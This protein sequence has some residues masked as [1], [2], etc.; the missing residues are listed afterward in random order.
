MEG[1]DFFTKQTMASWTSI[2]F[3]FAGEDELE[4]Y[5]QKDL[6]MGEQKWE[7]FVGNILSQKSQLGK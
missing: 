3:L 7:I 2:L 6:W 4:E 1:F 5:L